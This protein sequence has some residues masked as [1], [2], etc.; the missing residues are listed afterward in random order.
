MKHIK[1]T[2]RAM[3]LLPSLLTTLEDKKN[4]P[5]REV[6]IVL[7]VWL[8]T[9]SRLNVSAEELAEINKGYRTAIIEEVV[10]KGYLEINKYQGS[11]RLYYSLSPKGKRLINTIDELT[12]RLVSKYGYLEELDMV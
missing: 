4:L 6:K 12:G 10:N 9:R 8:L 5:R 1:D 2:L 3:V 11:K 7:I